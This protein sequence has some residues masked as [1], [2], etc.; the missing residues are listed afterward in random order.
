MPPA[1]VWRMSVRRRGPRQG[2]PARQ[3]ARVGG[4]TPSLAPRGRPPPASVFP[5]LS[6]RNQ[7]YG[8]DAKIPLVDMS[9]P[10]QLA[11]LRGSRVTS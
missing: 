4:L 1:D 8:S 7:N 2:P 10:G 6:C 11:G 9:E 5:R 3:G